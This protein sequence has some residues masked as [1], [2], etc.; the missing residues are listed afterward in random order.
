MLKGG[1]HSQQKMMIARVSPE[2]TGLV[3]DPLGIISRGR[4][5]PHPTFILLHNYRTGHPR[6]SWN[7]FVISSS[8][9]EI[10]SSNGGSLKS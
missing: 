9:N 5:G 4:K 3:G 2:K 10:P 6:S 7:R 8:L 1:N